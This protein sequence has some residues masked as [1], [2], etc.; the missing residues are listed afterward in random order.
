M[1]KTAI[2]V[3]A[4]FMVGM[5][6]AQFEHP[7]LVSGKKHVKTVILLPIHVEITKQGMKGPEP[8]MEESRRVEKDLGPVI[9]ESLKKEGCSVDDKTITVDT[10]A[11]DSELRYI[12]D[13]LQKQYDSQVGIMTKKS[14]DV[15]KGRYSLGEAVTRLPAGE[16]ADALLFVRA[17]GQVL[18]NGKKA[19]GWLVT[20]QVWDTVQVTFGVVDSKTG[21]VLYFAKPLML[22][23]M[24]KDPAE[25]HSGIEKS[26]KNFAKA[27]GQPTAVAEKEPEKPAE[28]K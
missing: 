5:C 19:F 11:Q 17:T 2:F 25:L 18:T 13:D 6:H 3:V 26:F 24:A 7:D 12:V 4:L 14:K 27:N 10:L 20:G 21:D 9:V 15:R 1:K 22:K 28:A 16:N 23:N 8:M